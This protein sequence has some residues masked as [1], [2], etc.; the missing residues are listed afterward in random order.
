MRLDSHPDGSLRLLVFALDDEL[1]RR[2]I[3]NTCIP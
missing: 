1:K 3:F 2:I